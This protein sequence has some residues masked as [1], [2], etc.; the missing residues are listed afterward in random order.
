MTEFM[1]SI[2]FFDQDRITPCFG[3]NPSPILPF[4]E[5]LHE[6]GIKDAPLTKITTK[7]G[8]KLTAFLM[9]DDLTSQDDTTLLSDAH[10]D[11]KA[12]YSF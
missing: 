7:N 4:E 12:S 11:I 3:S 1:S 5:G 10:F 8:P 9:E 2:D 6:T